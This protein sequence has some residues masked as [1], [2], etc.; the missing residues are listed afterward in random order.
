MGSRRLGI[1][2]KDRHRETTDKQE[3][4]RISL[5]MIYSLLVIRVTTG[6]LPPGIGI[7]TTQE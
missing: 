6:H 5:I 1:V 2:P 4:T 7:T 3:S